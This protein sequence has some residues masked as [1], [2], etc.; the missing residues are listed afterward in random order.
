[1]FTTI[2]YT[3]VLNTHEEVDHIVTTSMA[4]NIKN[5]IGSFLYINNNSGFV[6]QIIEGETIAVRHL[7]RRIFCDPR[8]RA[9]QVRYSRTLGYRIIEDVGITFIKGDFTTTEQMMHAIIGDRKKMRQNLLNTA[10][11]IVFEEEKGTPE[12]QKRAKTRK[13][14]SSCWCFLSRRPRHSSPIPSSAVAVQPGHVL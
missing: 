8:H 3:S 11:D 9:V 10:A 6:F 5:D 4:T 13:R 7:M 2:A 12:A 1:M 14:S